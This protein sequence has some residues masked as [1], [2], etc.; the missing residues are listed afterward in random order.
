M[1]S[2]AETH[3]GG[4]TAEQDAALAGT[5]GASNEPDSDN[6]GEGGEQQEDPIWRADGNMRDFDQHGDR[7][8]VEA[9]VSLQAGER[10]G[11]TLSADRVRVK[12]TIGF[13]G[14]DY[15]GE[16]TTV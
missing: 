14:E 4:D 15:D 9:R 1:F 3:I 13:D 10:L 12:F 2:G 5:L 16:W 7:G 6:G 11:G 8:G